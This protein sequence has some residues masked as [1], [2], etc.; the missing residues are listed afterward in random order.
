[1]LPINTQ[2]PHHNEPTTSDDVPAKT[3]PK[4]THEQIV[5]LQPSSIPFPHRIRKEKEEAQQK[6]FLENLKQLHI[7]IPFTEAFAQMP[8][9]AKFL[10]G[11]LS[12]KTRLEEACTV[13]FN[14]RCFTVLLNKL[15]SKGKDPGSFTIPCDNGNLRIDNALA[16]LGASISLMPYIM[17][18]KLG[19][20]EPKPTI[21]SLE[22]ADRSIQYPR[23]IAE[24]VLIKV[25]KFILPIDFVILDMR[26]DFRIPI[27]LR[28]PFLATARAMIDVF[29][30]KIALSV[31]DDEVTFEID[32]SIKIL[33]AE[34]DECYGIDDLDETIHLEAHELL[35][36]DQMDSFLVNNLEK[37]IVQSNPKCRDDFEEPIRRITQEDM[38]Y[39]KTQG[40]TGVLEKCKGA[41]TW[42]MSDIKGISPSFCTHKILMEESF[43]PVIQP[44]R[45]L[46]LKVQDVV[47]DEIVKLLNSGLIYPISD[48]FF[49]IPIA[50][51]DQEKTTFT[52]PYGT[53]AYRRMSFGLCNAPMTFQRCTTVIFHDMVEDFM[54]VF[55]DNLLVFDYVNY[56]VKKVVPPKWTPERKKRFF[57]QVKNNTHLDYVRTMSQNEMLQNNIQVCEVFDVW[58]LDFM[59]S[60]PDSRGNKYILV[61]VDYV[62]K[63]VEAQELPTN[64][65]RVVVKF[66]KGLFARF[67]VPKALISDRGTHFC[68]SQLEK[69]LMKYGVTHRISKTYHAQTNGQT[70][71]TNR[72]IKH[73]LERSVRYNPK[74]WSKKLHDALWAFRTAYKTPTRCTPFR[75]VYGKACHLPVEI[76]HKAYWAR[77]Q[78]NM[79]L[80][81]VAKNCFIELN[82]LI[83]LRD[84]AYENTRIYKEKTKKWHDSRLR[85]AKDFKNGDKVLLFN[86][87]LKLHPGKFKSKWTGPFIVKTMYLYGAVEITDKYG[88]SFKVNGHRLKKYHDKS[89]NMDDNEF[90]E[91][92]TNHTAYPMD[93]AETMMRRRTVRDAVAGRKV[94]SNI[95]RAILRNGL[96]NITKL[97]CGD[98]H[99]V[100][101]KT[102]FGRLLSIGISNLPNAEIYDGLAIIGGANVDQG[103]RLS[104]KS[105]LNP[106]TLLLIPDIE[107]FLSLRSFSTFSTCRQYEETTIGVRVGYLRE[108]PLNSALRCG[109]DS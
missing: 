57:S 29:N 37:C 42:K 61:A 100:G 96:W 109:L 35:E 60:F 41:I 11:L 94:E 51:E 20:G 59:G 23:G 99:T 70:E 58:G 90:V 44:Q 73:I 84:G 62:S 66:L 77:K 15:P 24:N 81:T 4:K 2:Y 30:K 71:I 14:E 28:R 9:Y 55:M 47:K 12:N 88:S 54:E 105:Q 69:A 39:P 1:M 87:R 45:R 67:G 108:L 18:E 63:W 85:G 103:E 106:N 32:Q 98:G 49:Q 76:K 33:L 104:K 17:Y 38:A 68:N 22:L 10:K 72:A 89:F 3:K 36:D 21:T 75:M 46:N 107:I 26:E 64:Y 7:N 91:I 95:Q 25:D 53:F 56:I 48:S 93:L 101:S 97:Y 19:L 65:A 16:N 92:D 79:D 34:D 74:D 52:Y 82:E 13:T 40:N 80:M 6:K 31:R 43:K 5:E 86:S 102:S 83:E 78:C 50:P 27:I 8:K